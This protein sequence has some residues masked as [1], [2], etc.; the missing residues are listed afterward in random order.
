MRS[1]KALLATTA[2]AGAALILVYLFV[3]GGRIPADH[4][5][6]PISGRVGAVWFCWGNGAI[7]DPH[8][9]DYPEHDRPCT[10]GELRAACNMPE[11]AGKPFCR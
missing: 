1:P 5:G 3:G 7:P 2:L 10:Q 8:D 9:Y 4:D 11:H 6:N